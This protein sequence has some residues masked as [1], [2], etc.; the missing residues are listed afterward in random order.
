M[1][2]TCP[3][4]VVKAPF[5]HPHFLDVNQ[6]Q[7]FLLKKK[8]V[9]KGIHVGPVVSLTEENKDAHRNPFYLYDL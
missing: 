4:F 9:Q 8:V 2:A 3:K 6:D 1:S 7:I 5:P